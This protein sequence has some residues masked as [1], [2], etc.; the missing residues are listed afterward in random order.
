MCCDGDVVDLTTHHAREGTV[1]GVGAAAGVQALGGHGLRG[2]VGG[3]LGEVP[4]ELGSRQAVVHSQ[5]Q[6]HTGLW[7]GRE[8]RR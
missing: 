5:V 3:P 2:E 7:M 6:G 4:V 8:H 1:G